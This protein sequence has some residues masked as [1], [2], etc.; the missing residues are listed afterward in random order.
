MSTRKIQADSR[1]T[2]FGINRKMKKLSSWPEIGSDG[3]VLLTPY[4]PKG[5]TGYDDDEYIYLTLCN[6]PSSSVFIF[7][8]NN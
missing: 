4:G 7:G 2:T 6:T 5:I 3:D 8:Y 1:W